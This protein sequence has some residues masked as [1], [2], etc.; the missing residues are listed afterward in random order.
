MDIIISNVGPSTIRV[1]MLLPY[2]E[3][4]LAHQL[5]E[6]STIY[7]KEYQAYGVYYDVEMPIK[8]YST[9]RD[10]DLENII[11]YRTRKNLVLLLIHNLLYHQIFF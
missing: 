7:Q 1:K 11:Q 4:K 5:E 10:F 3:G 9:Y 6:T 2:K 8:I